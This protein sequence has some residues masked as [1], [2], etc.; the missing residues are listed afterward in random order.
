MYAQPYSF[1]SICIAV[2]EYGK[3]TVDTYIL[4][5][6][7]SSVIEDASPPSCR[8]LW[9]YDYKTPNKEGSMNSLLPGCYVEDSREGAHMTY[10]W[11]Y[12][13]DWSHTS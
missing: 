4:L 13:F 8:I 12:I 2:D 10:Y 3:V 7:Y 9:N 11:F 5:T 1:G 6:W